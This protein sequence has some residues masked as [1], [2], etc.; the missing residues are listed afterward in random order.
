MEAYDLYEQ[1]GWIKDW[2]VIDINDEAFIP[3]EFEKDGFHYQTTS[4]TE[5]VLIPGESEAYNQSEITI[6]ATV[7][8]EG[9]TYTVTAIGDNAFYG[10]GLSSVTIP[11][12]VTRMGEY[13][14]GECW[15]LYNI[16]VL[17]QTPP[18]IYKSTFAN[19]DATVYVPY[20]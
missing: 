2:Q 6:P 1:Q 12:G 20:G 18:T 17:A 8:H 5:V 3:T 19:W 15:S 10:R 4:E 13:A 14:F 16:T 11:E 9:V 7:E